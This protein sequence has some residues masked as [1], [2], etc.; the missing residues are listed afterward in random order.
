MEVGLFGGSFGLGVYGGLGGL[1]YWGPRR[2][3]FF[4]LLLTLTAAGY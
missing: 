2:S 4:G 3:D 1:A